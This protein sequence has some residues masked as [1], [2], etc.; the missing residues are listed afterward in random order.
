ML[1]KDGRVNVNAVGTTFE[2]PI[3]V[4][5]ANEPIMFKLFIKHGELKP[6]NQYQLIHFVSLL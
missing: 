4:L 6:M 3:Y 2:Y 1:L 5:A